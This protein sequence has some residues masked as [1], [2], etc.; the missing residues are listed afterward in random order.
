VYGSDA[1]R[2]YVGGGTGN[3]RNTA[4]GTMVARSG[5][6]RTRSQGIELYYR[7]RADKVP[8][9][10]TIYHG[11]YPIYVD[12]NNNLW[13]DIDLDVNGILHASLNKRVGGT[14]TELQA[15]TGAG[16]YTAGTWLR[17]RF[18]VDSAGARMRVWVDGQTE[19]TTW[20][21]ST[22]DTALSGGT[23]AF[24]ANTGGATLSNAPVLWQIDDLTAGP[25]STGSSSGPSFT[26]TFTRTVAEGWGT[27]YAIEYGSDLT[28]STVGSGV[29]RQRVTSGGTMV[30]RLDFARTT[31]EV[32]ERIRADKIPTGAEATHILHAK[33]AGTTNVRLEL[34]LTTAGTLHARLV[35]S[36][37]GTVTTIASEVSLG[38]YTAGAWWRARLQVDGS[39]VRAKVWAESGAEP[40]SWTLSSS[41][42]ALATTSAT[43][44]VEAY[45]SATPS[46]APV[47][48]E[49]DDLYAGPL[50]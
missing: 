20:L 44:A 41:D 17:V 14:Y 11:S 3:Q 15:V 37:S 6:S 34:R 7:L 21:V 10:G 25:V 8:V 12:A 38:S 4:G 19:P 33:S 29:G 28:R 42:T 50:T 26:D 49:T 13:A 46:N 1:T 24:E 30:R 32:S 40:G 22:T 47:L 16:G 27:D 5:Y 18:Q 36:A 35:K 9:G 31:I 45:G 48:W 39:G 43:I 23:A 2:S